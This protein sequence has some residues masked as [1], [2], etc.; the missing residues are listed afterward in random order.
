[1]SRST[2]ISRRRLVPK[3]KSNSTGLSKDFARAVCLTPNGPNVTGARQAAHDELARLE[4]EI[5]EVEQRMGYREIE[6]QQES[7]SGAVWDAEYG[8]MEAEPVTAAGAVALL[9]FVAGLME[10]F[11]PDDEHD[12]Y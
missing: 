2:L 11:F 8:V 3:M 4:A 10:G 1:M 5:S 6:A 9:R 12:H 7:A